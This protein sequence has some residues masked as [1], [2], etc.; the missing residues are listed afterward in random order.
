MGKIQTEFHENSL[1]IMVAITA[2]QIDKL[3][4]L[5]MI[6]KKWIIDS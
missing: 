5:L 6:R 3:T 2:L 4:K 1:T